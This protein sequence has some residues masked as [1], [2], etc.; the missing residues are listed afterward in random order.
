MAATDSARLAR[1]YAYNKL[2]T[3]IRREYEQR[4]QGRKRRASA[5]AADSRARL[6]AEKELAGEQKKLKKLQSDSFLS[7]TT[8]W[9]IH[10]L[11]AGACKQRA[12]EFNLDKATTHY[13]QFR[14]GAFNLR[15]G[16]L[17]PR[18][19]QMSVTK[20]L[21]CDYRDYRLD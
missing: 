2:A 18:T 9:V 12:V 3:E 19:K 20:Y 4:F 10:K 15:A 1:D 13:F 5:A 8:S 7:A 17:E 6:R 16:Q 14:N 11:R 21:D